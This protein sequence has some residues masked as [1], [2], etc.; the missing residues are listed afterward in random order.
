MPMMLGCVTALT[1]TTAENGA[2]IVIPGSH[3]WG[4]DR[5]PYDHEA[6]PAELEPGSALIFVG[7]LYHAGGGNTTKWVLIRSDRKIL[8]TDRVAEINP[9]R[10]LESFSASQSTVLQKINS[11]WCPQRRPS[12][13]HHRRRDFSDTAF[14]GHP[15]ASW[16][17]KTL[18][19]YSSA[20]KTRRPSTCSGHPTCRRCARMR[21]SQLDPSPN[22]TKSLISPRNAGL[23]VPPGGLAASNRQ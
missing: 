1:K 20:S 23:V 22:S 18:C 3:L 12:D 10:L 7:N 17:I 9:V 6:V 14:V 16:S 11:S 4:P 13:C 5:C 19:A 21:P 15:W 2:T 8:L